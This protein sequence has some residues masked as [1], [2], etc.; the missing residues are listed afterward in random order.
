MSLI[1]IEKSRNSGSPIEMYKFF[2]DSFTTPYY[3]TSSTESQTY[4]S[5]TYTPVAGLKRSTIEMAKGAEANAITIEM[6]GGNELAKR[7]IRY[8]PPKAVWVHIY[9]KHVLDADNEVSL[10]WQGRVS[11]VSHEGSLASFTCE[12]M[13][14]ALSK[15]GLEYTF[16]S[17]CN[18]MF[19]DS[20]CQVN[21]NDYTFT[22]PIVGLDSTIITSPTFS[23]FPTT[24]T[25]VPEGYWTTG[26]VTRVSNGDIKHII[27]HGT[28]IG[29]GYTTSQ[30]KIITPFEDLQTSETITVTAGCSHSF[31]VC[32]SKFDNAINFN[33]TPFTG[34]NPFQK[35]ISL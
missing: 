28:E 7:Y 20:L 1:N 26:F 11:G 24:L 34:D 30:I 12:P 29:S 35:N 14:T 3:F 23:I 6:D 4:Q 18:N 10:Y 22:A 19:G 16:S 17:T 8:L 5:Q 9:R 13:I 2:S 21:L 27:A 15:R 32:R 31:D 33:G 25:A